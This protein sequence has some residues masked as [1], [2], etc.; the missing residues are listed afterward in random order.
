MLVYL[1]V[2]IYFFS[3]VFTT[4][5]LFSG[6]TASASV[7]TREL[8]YLASLCHPRNAAEDSAEM[9]PAPLRSEVTFDYLLIKIRRI[10]GRVLGNAT[11]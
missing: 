7:F 1:H 8:R 2:S 10:T 5:N 11:G 3:A 9:L 4:L 6:A